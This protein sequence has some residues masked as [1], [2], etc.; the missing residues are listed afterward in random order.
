[1]RQNSKFL[2]GFLAFVILFSCARAPQQIAEKPVALTAED[3]NEHGQ[4]KFQS[5]DYIGAIEDFTEAIKINPKYANVYSNR[6]EA[7]FHLGNYARAIADCTHAIKIDLENVSAYKIRGAAQA[8][9]GDV[10]SERGNT[11]KAR[12]LYRAGIVDYIESNKRKK[13]K[14]TDLSTTALESEKGREYTVRVVKRM[15]S[16][17]SGFGSS[18][19]FF[20]DRDKIVTNIHVAALPGPVFVIVLDDKTIGDVEGITAFNVKN[21][22]VILKITGEG[23][24]LP[25]GDSESVEIGETVIAVGYPSDKYKVTKGTLHGRNWNNWFQTTAHISPGNSGG[26]LLNS[27]NEVIGVNTKG[28]NSYS[29]AVPTKILEELLAESNPIEP[30]AVWQQRKHIRA[31]AYFNKGQKKYLTEDYEKAIIDFNTAIQLNPGFV[32]VYLSRGVAKIKL[33]DY[34]GAMA[35]NTTAIQL[36]PKHA[37]AYCNRGVAKW[38]L[39]VTEANKD[40]VARSHDLYEAAIEDYTKSIHLNRGHDDAYNNRGWVKYLLGAS[41]AAQ[42][43]I[44]KAQDLYKAAI[45]DF[46]QAIKINPAKVLAYNNRGHAKR[47]LGKHKEAIK[48]YEKAEELE[49]AAE[50]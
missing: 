41:E 49:N 34:D 2:L 18:S 28:G 39:G 25:L 35:D 6:G 20:V 38:L 24:P 50:K 11:E 31:H 21:D 45:V 27:K 33:G 16:H 30:L 1:M 9:L 13:S 22:L 12:N 8:A 42:G 46:D 17:L 5:D 32:D 47:S 19:G 4:T 3:Y 26:P 40:N 29:L 37:N 14:N 7:E 15:Q 43:N 36:A 44:A 10:E 23:T 48:D